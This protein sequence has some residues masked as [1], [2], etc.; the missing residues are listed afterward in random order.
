MGLYPLV[1]VYQKLW[2]I[3][4][5]SWGK[6]TSSTGPL[7]IFPSGK[8]MEHDDFTWFL[9]VSVLSWGYP[10]SPSISNDGLFRNKNHP[11]L[12]WCTPKNTM[13]TSIWWTCQA[14]QAS[15]NLWLV[16]WTPLKNISQLGW[17]FPIYGKI[18]FMAT[19][20]PT[21]RRVF[22]AGFDRKIL[23]PMFFGTCQCRRHNL[24]D[25]QRHKKDGPSHLGQQERF[26]EF[27][28]RPIRS[29]NTSL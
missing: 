21:R 29:M 12:A 16:V 2:K 13:D 11:K 8:W 25:A 17:L 26:N 6:S 19:K 4:I 7:N 22:S 24:L 15:I 3:I 28:K 20:P 18:E 14:Y 5:L 10:Q 27:L 1:N 9:E 23:H